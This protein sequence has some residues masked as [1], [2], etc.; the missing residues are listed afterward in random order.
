MKTSLPVL[1]ISV[2]IVSRYFLYIDESW[3]PSSLSLLSFSKA[4]IVKSIFPNSANSS[5]TVSPHL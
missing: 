2:V 5:T 4:K 3:N 1:C